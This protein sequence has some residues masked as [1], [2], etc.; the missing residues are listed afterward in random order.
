MKSMRGHIAMHAFDESSPGSGFLAWQLPSG[1]T[2]DSPS[3]HYNLLAAESSILTKQVHRQ[4]ISAA[5]SASEKT[6]FR[7]DA[8]RMR[9]SPRNPNALRPLRQQHS[10]RC[11]LFLSS[12]V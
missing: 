8:L 5:R 6:G 10:S 12:Q 7:Q 1:V 11:F 3:F 4:S 9:G 2:P